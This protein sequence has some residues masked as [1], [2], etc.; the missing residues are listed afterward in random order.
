LRRAI[1]SERIAEGTAKAGEFNFHN[2]AVGDFNA[3]AEAEN[4]RAEEMNVDIARAAMSGIFEMVM[5][6]IGDGVRHVFFA[7][8][9]G[10]GPERFS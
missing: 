3:I 4:I 10:F 1:D 5:F 7:S 8:G 6:E 9:K 2:V